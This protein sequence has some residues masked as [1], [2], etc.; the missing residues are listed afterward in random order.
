MI[1]TIRMSCPGHQSCSVACMN[2]LRKY[3]VKWQDEKS[4]ANSW[5]GWPYGWRYRVGKKT[6][7]LW[8]WLTQS[9]NDKR[10][11]SSPVFYRHFFPLFSLCVPYQIQSEAWRK[12]YCAT[13]NPQCYI[14]WL[15]KVPLCITLRIKMW[16][17]A[18]FFNL[19]RAKKK[20]KTILTKSFFMR[21]FS[22]VAKIFFKR[23]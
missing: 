3:I 6:P 15:F 17:A 2:Q 7:N 19:L 8:P 10:H 22:S 5:N 4:N 16:V 20:S 12:H 9:W 14:Q 23:F 13:C 21:L 1:A 11:E 18:Y